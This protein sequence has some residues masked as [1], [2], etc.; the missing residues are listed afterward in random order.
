MNESTTYTIAKQ[1]QRLW[2]AL[3]MTSDPKSTLDVALTV[4]TD[5]TTGTGA[6][7]IKVRYVL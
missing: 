7:G 1:S 6:V 2:E 4:G 5:I 3:G